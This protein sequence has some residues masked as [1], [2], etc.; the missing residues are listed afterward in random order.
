[1]A[2]GNTSTKV[3]VWEIG[4]DNPPVTL[5]GHEAGIQYATY[6]PNGKLLAT[7]GGTELLLWDAEK[8]QL[9]K[10]I[11][12]PA[13]WVAFEPDD[14]T[15]LT[16]TLDPS[17]STP[18]VTRWDLATSKSQPLL[19]PNRGPGHTV[20][21]LSSDGK[22]LFSLINDGA[23][24]E[25]RV[26]VSNLLAL[27]KTYPAILQGEEKLADNAVRLQVAQ[28][29]SDRKQFAAAAR[30]WAE[31]LASDPQLGDDRQP[32]HRY[33]AARAAVLAIDQLHHLPR[34]VGGR[35]RGGR[36]RRH[37][38]QHDGAHQRSHALDDWSQD[39][40]ALPREEQAEDCHQEGAFR[41]ARR[42]ARRGP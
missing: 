17:G 11:E 21:H 12:T 42:L 32:Q 31:A 29:A 8:L 1:L 38:A 9:M 24:M 2:W 15:L 10:K 34:L 39:H 19:L 30:I 16:A 33:H 25:W 7:G 28:I 18:V 35:R 40:P 27:A 6:S 36:V 3:K 22:T 23:G 20:Y 41:R 26:R 13:G 4:S 14:K 37:Y 5:D